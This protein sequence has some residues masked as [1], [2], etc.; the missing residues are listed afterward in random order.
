M[1]VQIV[2]NECVFHYS[3]PHSILKK[4][5]MYAEFSIIRPIEP[6]HSSESNSSV[7]LLIVRPPVQ[8]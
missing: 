3:F 4:D 7:E 1:I 5:Y 6:H 2:Y 8:I